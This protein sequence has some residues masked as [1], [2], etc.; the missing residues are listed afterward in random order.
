MSF[1]PSTPSTTKYLDP[2]NESQ[3]D[4][5]YQLFDKIV[6]VHRVRD[7]GNSAS[8]WLIWYERLTNIV[9]LRLDPFVS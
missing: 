6:E 7:K 3:L 1:P 5:G 4:R 9:G 8:Q 2:N